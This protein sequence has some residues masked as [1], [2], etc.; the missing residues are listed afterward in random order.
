[1][2]QSNQ[3]ERYMKLTHNREGAYI[4]GPSVHNQRVERLH[5]DTT[6][7][8][9]AHYIDLFVSLEVAGIFDP[10]NNTHIFS[11]HIV[12]TKRIQRSLDRFR[13]GW[14]NHPMSTEGNKTPTQLWLL[15]TLSNEKKAFKEVETLLDPDHE[16]Y[17]VDTDLTNYNG[18][19]E[20]QSVPV[21]DICMGPKHDELMAFIT[22]TVALENEDNNYGIDTFIEVK[23]VVE[24]FFQCQ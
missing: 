11:L 16:L 10:E 12:Y 6:H 14:N 18:D 4:R 2:A 24:N 5:Y 9:L 15:G 13:E 8:A 22:S 17:G 21:Q 1:M 19:E 23:T 20:Q 3:I 7:C